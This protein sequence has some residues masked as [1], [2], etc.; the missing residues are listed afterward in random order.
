[1]KLEQEQRATFRVA[2]RRDSG[3]EASLSLAGKRLRAGV[4]DVSAE[5]ISLTLERGVL[6]ALK[7]G[8]N[9]DVEVSFEGETFLLHGVIRSEHGGGYGI[10]F[11]AARSRG[12]PESA[13]SVR[14]HLRASAAHVAL[15]APQ[16]ADAAGVGGPPIRRFVV[17]S[18]P[19]S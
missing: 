16:G 5:G 8:G 7:V 10:F 17:H 18:V 2:V 1:M 19:A 13:R 9:V 4:R 11:P 15:A 3:I 12:A 14:A 6:A